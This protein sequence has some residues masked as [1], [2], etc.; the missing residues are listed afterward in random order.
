MIAWVEGGDEK[1]VMSSWRDEF[2]VCVCVCLY[3]WLLVVIR[4]HSDRLWAARACVSGLPLLVI[5]LLPGDSLICVWCLHSDEYV[6]EMD[7]SFERQVSHDPYSW[8]YPLPLIAEV[9]MAITQRFPTCFQTAQSVQMAT[10][11]LSPFYLVE[12]ME[13]NFSQFIAVLNFFFFSLGT[14]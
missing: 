9:Q 4:G 10:D 5:A 11:A 8:W 13:Y 3:L 2:S 7:W 6:V 12:I 14:M 1:N